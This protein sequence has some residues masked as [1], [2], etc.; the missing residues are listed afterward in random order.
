MAILTVYNT[1]EQKQLFSVGKLKK[2]ENCV[3][4]LQSYGKFS[5]NIVG[6]KVKIC[7]PDQLGRSYEAT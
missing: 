2:L 5:F 1:H 7:K 6:L 3:A 4:F